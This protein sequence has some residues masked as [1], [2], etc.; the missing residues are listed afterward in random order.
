MKPEERKAQLGLDFKDLVQSNKWAKKEPLSSNREM[1]HQSFE[2]YKSKMIVRTTPRPKHRMMSARN[3]K[4][5]IMKFI[6]SKSRER[7]ENEWKHQLSQVKSGIKLWQNLSNL[8]RKAILS[9]WQ[10]YK[11]SR[12]LSECGIDMPVPLSQWRK[13][14][15]RKKKNRKRGYKHHRTVVEWRPA[16]A[17]RTLEDSRW[18]SA[19]KK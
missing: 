9:W 4:Y 16:T 1:W 12:V 7:K 5:N 18:K 11:M 3:G 2:N 10:G 14:D 17:Y 8:N 15:A 6:R 19:S 13:I